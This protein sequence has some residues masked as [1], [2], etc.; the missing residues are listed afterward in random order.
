MA[1]YKNML[2]AQSTT[3][4]KDHGLLSSSPKAELIKRL[5]EDDLNGR[6]TQD[7]SMIDTDNVQYGSFESRFTF[8]ETKEDDVSCVRPGSY[9]T[10]VAD[11]EMLDE[12]P[13]LKNAASAHDRHRED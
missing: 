13:E 3:M 12:Q 10:G 8:E 2:K 9:E 7:E 5:Q 1:E 6:S 4:L 11:D